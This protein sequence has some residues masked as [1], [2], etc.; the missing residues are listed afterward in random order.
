MPPQE[1]VSE[2]QRVYDPPEDATATVN[3]LMRSGHAHFFL[4]ES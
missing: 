1:V 2:P 4:E 3:G